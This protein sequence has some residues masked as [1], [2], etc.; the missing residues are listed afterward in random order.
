MP[1]KKRWNLLASG[2]N[3]LYRRLRPWSW[4]IHMQVEVTNYCDLR[5]PVCPT[6]MGILDRPKAM[7]DVDMYARL[8]DEVGPYLLTALLW[9]WGE[10]LVHPQFA[11][12][13]RITRSHGV[14]PILSTNGQNLHDERVQE[15]LLRQPPEHLIVA[16]DG[17]TDQTNSRY[18][19]GAK[20]AGALE[21]VGRLARR[22]RDRGQQLPVLHMRY[23]V[24][25]HNQH[26]RPDVERFAADN[27]F[28]FLT[29]RTLMAIGDD[30]VALDTLLPT[31]P[32]YQAYEVEGDKPRPRD[33][34]ACQYAFCFPGLQA[35]GTVVP[36]DQDFRG[37]HAYGRFGD[38]VSFADLWF[39]QKARQLRRTIRADRHALSTCR[40]CPFADRKADSC[41]VE[42]ADLPASND[43]SVAAP[44]RGGSVGP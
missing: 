25:Q 1:L 15:D 6:G 35:D 32:R 41:S 19:I 13:I 9:G 36:C 29:I 10:P 43:P 21:G 38:G 40:N 22:K 44:A 31:D 14:L 37:S 17:L 8:M 33:D 23:M 20:L 11:E 18:R 3:L 5:C 12:L 34:F 7:L 4:P 27:G 2:M 16:I 30:G 26:E 28:E 24:M 39:N 42:L